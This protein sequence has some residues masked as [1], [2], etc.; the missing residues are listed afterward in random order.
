MTH[1]SV[2]PRPSNV[3]IEKVYYTHRSKSNGKHSLHFQSR[4]RIISFG[5][6]QN[7]SL[8]DQ[9]ATGE[10][11]KHDMFYST[12]HELCIRVW[13]KLRDENPLAVTCR[14]GEF[15]T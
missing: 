9:L 2:A 14:T 3:I 5:S 7:T 15:W 1:E 10:T 8:A 13:A 12:R 11:P 4:F 6:C